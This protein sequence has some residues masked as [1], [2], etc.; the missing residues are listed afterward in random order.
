MTLSRRAFL[1]WSGVAGYGT[2]ALLK[3]PPDRPR[4][5]K[6]KPTTTT[7]P[8]TTTTTLPPDQSA[9]TDAYQDGY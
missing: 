7:A 1:G 8:A 3:P 5:Q 2:W 9:Y 4:P 6:P